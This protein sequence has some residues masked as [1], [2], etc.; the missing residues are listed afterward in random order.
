MV[1]IAIA[2]SA[3]VIAIQ[4]IS[5]HCKKLKYQRRI[6]LVTNGRGSLDGEEVSQISDKIK[7]DG[8]ELVVVYGGL[9]E[10]Y[11]HTLIVNSGVDFDDTEYGYKEEDKD[12]DK[13][14]I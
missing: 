5:K 4:M 7:A 14:A 8:I 9:Q 3:I 6:V 13:V 2:I 12:P 1:L 10:H 11:G